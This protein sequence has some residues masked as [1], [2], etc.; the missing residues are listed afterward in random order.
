MPRRSGGEAGA[1]RAAAQVRCYLAWVHFRRLRRAAVRTQAIYWGEL[2]RRE[3]EVLLLRHVASKILGAT[4]RMVVARRA[5]A[6]QR[7]A[8]T[9]VNM[10][11]RRWL[12][13]IKWADEERRRLA[14]EVRDTR[15]LDR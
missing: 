8:A 6:R 11:V 12:L 15:A 14:E 1:G 5:F 10:A 4:W 2:A 9:T 13:R 3:Y 7:A